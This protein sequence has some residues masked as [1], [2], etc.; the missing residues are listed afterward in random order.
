[1]P[2]PC[3]A[4]DDDLAGFEVPG[5]VEAGEGSDKYGDAQE[6]V[7]AVDPGD[8]VEEVTALVCT[9]ED[10][11]GGELAPGDPLAGEEG[12]P[13]GDGRGEPWDGAAG[14][15]FA[16]AKPLVH[17]VIFAEHL[18]A[19]EFHGDGADD[20]DGG[21]EPEDAG[22]CGGCPLVDV[23]IV[24]VDVSG[25]LIDEEGGNDGNEEH[26]IAGEGEEDAHAIAMKTFV[27]ATAAIGAIVPVIAV[28]A[29][30]GTLVGWRTPAG[31]VV[32]VF[33]ATAPFLFGFIGRNG[34]RHD[35][36]LRKHGL[37]TDYSGFVSGVSWTYT[38][39]SGSGV[40]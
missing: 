22:Y 24:G 1:V 3:G 37:G 8:E 39:A 5:D 25:R 11:L 33:E 27:G 38:S 26:E 29:A 16:D 4:V 2:V 23:A 13:E 10:V 31:A 7:G 21:V 18:A 36:S 19:G 20:E 9:E 35:G 14:D 34:G 28:A 15:G 17:D 6:E 30:A 12:E 40:H 32:V